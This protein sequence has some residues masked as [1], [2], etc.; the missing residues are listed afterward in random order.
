MK[1]PDVVVA[2][3]FSKEGNANKDLAIYAR[4]IATEYGVPIF[5][6]TDISKHLPPTVTV[7]TAEEGEKYLSTLGVS[8]SFAEVAKKKN[9]R[10]PFII[11]APCHSW[12]CQRDLKKIG[13]Q[14]VSD[15]YLR[16]YYFKFWYAPKDRQIWV[17]NPC[18]WWFREI[19]LRLMPWKLYS[20][21]AT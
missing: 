9:W 11:A 21:I 8:I 4:Y 1:K 18:I 10:K 6:Q 13:F 14:V 5:T 16:A 12:R 3:A 15:D 2:F 7:F 17:H 20:K 19:I